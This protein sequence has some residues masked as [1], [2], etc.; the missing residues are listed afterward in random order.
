MIHR[1]AVIPGDGIGQE[2]VPE[3]MRVLEA[4]GRRYG[5]TLHWTTFDWSCQVYARTGRMMPEDGLDR[6]RQFEAIFLGA[7]GWPGVPDHVSLWGLLIGT[8][9]GAMALVLGAIVANR[10]FHAH[11][12]LITGVFSAASATGQL[13][14]LPVIARTAVENGWRAAALIVSGFALLMAVL[15]ALLLRDRPQDQGLL[16]YGLSPDA[17]EAAAPPPAHPTV[18]P[19]VVA[20][21]T[22]ARASRTW[23]KT[24]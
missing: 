23:T 18:S 3:G 5:F 8:A 17:P 19:A 12:G 11:R 13:V 7:M 16:P 14:F 22:L 10:W 20:V 21:R 1:I 4:A 6:L 9:T 24:V 15:V 2:V